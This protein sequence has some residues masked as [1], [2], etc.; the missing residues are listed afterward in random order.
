MDGSARLQTVE[1][2]QSPRVH[3]I[4]AEFGALTDYPV[5]LNTSFNINGE[6]IVLTPDDALST[7]FNSGLTRLVVGKFLICK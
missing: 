2:E 6:P 1:R 3:R 5:V 7:F 4:I